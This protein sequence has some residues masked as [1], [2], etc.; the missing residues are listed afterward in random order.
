VCTESVLKK[1]SKV[2]NQAHAEIVSIDPSAALELE[3]VRGFFSAKDIASGRNV[4]GP[5]VHDEE[6]FASKR[7]TCCGQVIAC[8]V[9]ENLALAQR[10]SRL[11]RVT[12]SPSDG[13]AIFTIQDAIKRNSFYQGH[14]REIIQGDVEAGFRNAQH[15]LDGRS[16]AFLIGDAIGIGRAKR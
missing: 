3:G 2:R 13:P 10:A 8:V 11:V 9:A 6:V 4:F 12:Y 1:R 16:G 14:N 15:V 7:V 5:I